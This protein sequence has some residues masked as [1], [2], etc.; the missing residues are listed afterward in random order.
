LNQLARINEM[1]H[2]Y[3]PPAVLSLEQGLTTL[4]MIY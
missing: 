2:G 3:G 4:F 1:F